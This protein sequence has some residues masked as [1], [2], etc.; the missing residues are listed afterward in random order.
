MDIINALG[1]LTDSPL[2]YI[3]L[4]CIG[5]LAWRQRLHE[6]DCHRRNEETATHRARTEARFEEGERRML[7][8]E[9]K[10]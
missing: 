8:V 10:R 5:W 9:T 3:I 7:A 4:T 1:Q 2:D 6:K